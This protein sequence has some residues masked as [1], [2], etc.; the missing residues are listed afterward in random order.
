MR[1]G[2]VGQAD[3]AMASEQVLMPNRGAAIASPVI[4][5]VRASS[6]RRFA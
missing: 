2:L 5:T 6:L 1:I 4:A 3:C